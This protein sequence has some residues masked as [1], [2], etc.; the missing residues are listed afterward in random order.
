M[1]V[2]AFQYHFI[3]ENRQELDFADP[4]NLSKYLTGS[5]TSNSTC[6]SLFPKQSRKSRIPA[7]GCLVPTI[8]TS[9]PSH[10][11]SVLSNATSVPAA[12]WNCPFKASSNLHVAKSLQVSF[13]YSISPVFNTANHSPP[14]SGNTLGFW[15]LTQLVFLLQ[16]PPL[17]RHQR[18]IPSWPWKPEFLRAPSWVLLLPTPLSPSGTSAIP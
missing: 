13:S 17:L 14:F 3:Y 2:T 16:Q 12:H 11:P 4:W 7:K 18:L 1:G 9:L 10:L 8:S 15:K 5:L 6:S